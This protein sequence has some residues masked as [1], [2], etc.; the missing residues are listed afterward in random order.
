MLLELRDFNSSINK[1][2]TNNDTFQNHMLLRDNSE[3]LDLC[4]ERGPNHLFSFSS[5]FPPCSPRF[6]G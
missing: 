6:S 2:S 1:L 3:K 4:K 5:P